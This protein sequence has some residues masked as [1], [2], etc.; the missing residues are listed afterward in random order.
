MI[1]SGLSRRM[2][3]AGQP[4]IWAAKAGAWAAQAA[5]MYLLTRARLVG[6]LSPFAPA[7]MAA[8]MASGMNPAALLLGAAS[9]AW[10]AGE[11]LIGWIPAFSCLIVC[12][13]ALSADWAARRWERIGEMKEF[14][15]GTAA[16]LGLL[17][18][19]LAASGRIPYNVMTVCLSSAAAMFLAPALI[20]GMGVRV[21]RTRLMPEEQL[22]LSLLI[23]TALIGL[24][25]A[26]VGGLFLSQTAA[27][28]LTLVFSGAGAAMGALA[29]L[30][31]GTALT[32]GGSDPFIGS[33]LGLCGL[34]AG[35]VKKLPRIGAGL[36]FVLGNLLTVSWGVGYST[37]A[38]QA[39]AALT[40]CAA[41]CVVP[42]SLLDRLHG[43]M[44]G[45]YPPGDAENLAV[46][47]RQKAG[48]KLG[49]ISEIFGELAD[50][51]GEESILPGE[52]QIISRVRHA[53]C[54]GCAGYADC[55]MGDT[56]QAGRLMCRMAAEALSGREITRARDL[57]PDLIRH[58]RRS[59]QIDRRAVPLLSR[60]AKERRESMKRGEARSVMGR[61]FREAQ[62]LLDAL[63][64]QLQGGIC[65]NRQYADLVHAA[66]DRA[67]LAAREVTVMLDDRME[68]VCTLRDGVCATEEAWRAARLLTD[69][70]G[71]PFSPVM[72]RGRSVSEFELHLRQAP[73]LTAA[74]SSVS[75]AAEEAGE[76][77]DSHM[78]NLLPDGRLIAALS[79]G[80][81]Q[82][83]R[84]AQESAR[85]ISLLRKF[86]SAGVDREAALTAVNSLMVMREGEDMFATADLCVI[87]LYSGVASWSKLGAC[88]SY[89]VS[90]RGVKRIAGGRLPL[91]I[92]DQVEPASERIEVHPGDLIIMISDGIA[93]EMKEGQAAALEKEIGKVRHMKP[94]QAA[95]RILDW[96][97]KRDEGKERDDMTVIA[98]R[99][100]ARKIRKG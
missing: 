64:T 68:I 32:L 75:C 94:E 15:V 19:G 93:D 46:R 20:S 35:C 5:G 14:L 61:Q 21:G 66:L 44:A 43:W 50:G 39:W 52:Q 38:V 24:R 92:I 25:A 16:G 55:W 80:M 4:G 12:A 51:Y 69:E 29:G 85:C 88:S 98:A 13:F 73:A 86:V 26:P 17:I 87:D 63:S 30:A 58:C 1:G 71:V 28:L 3:A 36:A 8:G 47:M 70:L 49:G 72:S 65:V 54:D 76:C 7:A 10:G 81:G 31:A 37:G 84:A 41:Y 42:G 40:G 82:G 34:L 100:L 11:G 78:V 22:S 53:L 23:M 96:A 56:A 97:R 45:S 83:A 2:R 60:L 59:S 6:E 67:G 77:G 18:P 9:G 62:R 48:R 89:I 74:F 95:G 33:A 99:I 57:P 90:D 91:G 27:A 79:D